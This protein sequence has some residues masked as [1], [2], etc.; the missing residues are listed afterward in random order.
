MGAMSKY[1]IPIQGLVT[2]TVAVE[3]ESLEEAIEHA[4]D[5]VPQTDFGFAEFDGVEEWKHYGG[6]YKDGQQFDDP[7]EPEPARPGTA[8][9]ALAKMLEHLHGKPVAIA[10]VSE[11]GH[12]TFAVW[13]GTSGSNMDAMVQATAGIGSSSPDVRK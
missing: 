9:R 11:T 8:E 4:L 13:G 10:L 3:A 7:A 1:I 5:N 12:H 2:S 6:Y